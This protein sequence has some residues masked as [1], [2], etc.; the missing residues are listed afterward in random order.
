MGGGG[1]GKQSAGR[2]KGYSFC[3]LCR[4]RARAALQARVE[5]CATSPPAIRHP[6]TPM[7]ASLSTLYQLIFGPVQYKIVM[8]GLDNAGKTTILYR[9]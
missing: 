8:V 2:R 7:G 9:L 3:V 6:Q 1:G 5:N 4:C